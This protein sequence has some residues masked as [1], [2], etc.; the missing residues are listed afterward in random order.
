MRKVINLG[1]SNRGVSTSSSLMPSKGINT[2][3]LPQLL[4]LVSATEIGNWN[5]VGKGQFVKRGG[6]KKLHTIASIT[7]SSFFDYYHNNIFIV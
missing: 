1:G 2:N 7:D 6:L 4:G 3:D 5:T